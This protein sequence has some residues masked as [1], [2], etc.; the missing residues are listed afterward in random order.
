MRWQIGGDEDNEMI[1][2]LTFILILLCC[3]LSWRIGYQSGK[4]DHQIINSTAH[5][6]IDVDVINNVIA[7]Q[8]WLV[9]KPHQVLQE[10]SSCKH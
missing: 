3:W 9:I 2:I 4:R 8:G 10:Q 5:V 7:Q 6:T 1:Y